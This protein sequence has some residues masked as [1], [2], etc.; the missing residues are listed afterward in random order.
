MKLNYSY[1]VQGVNVDLIE[2]DG[3]KWLNAHD[4][5]VDYA[6]GYVS[7]AIAD[8]IERRICGGCGLEDMFLTFTALNKAGMTMCYYDGE[9]L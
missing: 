5:I 4:E 7:T 3:G 6:C 8:Y 2:T 9:D 1:E